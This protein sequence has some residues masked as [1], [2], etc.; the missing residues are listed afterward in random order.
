M[1]MNRSHREMEKHFRVWVYKEGEAP[2]FHMGPLNDIYSTEGQFMDEF[3]S[4]KSPFLAKDPN[5]AVSFFL[6]ISVVNII[7]Y[8]YRPY[9]DYSR[10]RLQNIF[11]DYIHLLSHRYPFWNTTSGADHFMLSCHDWVCYLFF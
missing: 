6:P 4:G 11:T 9:T 1:N 3:E 5:D 10:A 8:V 7:L 2:I